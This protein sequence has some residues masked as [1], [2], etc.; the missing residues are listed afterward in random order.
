MGSSS[1]KKKISVQ[2]NEAQS[3]EVPSRPPPTI[4]CSSNTQEQPSLGEPLV[5][6]CFTFG[7]D[8]IL[9]WPQIGP[10][11]GCQGRIHWKPDG[12]CDLSKKVKFYKDPSELKGEEHW[13]GLVEELY[14]KWK[15]LFSDFFEDSKRKDEE[16]EKESPILKKEQ[17]KIAVLKKR[18][19]G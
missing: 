12:K 19:E 6:L 3:S 7:T 18:T 2:L 15:E 11:A 16:S 9:K 1:E 10:F 13:R 5:F 14:V 4:S 17:K 8:D